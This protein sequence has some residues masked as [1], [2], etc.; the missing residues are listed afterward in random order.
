MPRTGRPSACAAAGR[1]TATNATR[2]TGSKRMLGLIAVT[3]IAGADPFSTT[4]APARVPRIPAVLLAAQLRHARVTKTH[5]CLAPVISREERQLASATSQFRTRAWHRSFP[6]RSSDYSGVEAELVKRSEQLRR[7]VVDAK[8]AGDGDA[9]A[10]PWPRAVAA[11]REATP[12]RSRRGGAGCPRSHRR[13]A[14][15]R[16]RARP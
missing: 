8:C 15:A 7:V 11:V 5:P 6:P 1:K 2:K 3:P 13:R 16:P 14:H 10:A 9:R 12:E 4:V